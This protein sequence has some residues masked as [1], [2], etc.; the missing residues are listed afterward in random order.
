MIIH[1]YLTDGFFDWG[2]LFLQS[3][4]YHNGED[5]RI[6]MDT[7]DLNA[8]Q[9]KQLKGIYGNLEVKNEPLDFKDISKRAR[10]DEEK[11]KALKAKV[12]RQSV[13]KESK[14]W[15][16]YI[17]VEDR[18]RNTIKRVMEENRKEDYL[19]HMDIDMYVRNKLD[20]LFNF[21]KDYDIS[22]RFRNKKGKET[23]DNRK[24]LGNIIGF[25]ICDD[26]LDFMDTWRK[27]IDAIPLYHKYKGYGQASFWY[28][29]LEHKNN[30]VWGDIP[31]TAK[32]KA[33][34]AI[35][36]TGNKGGKDK[37]LKKCREDFN[38]QS[39]K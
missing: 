35:L 8:K 10:I 6:I 22:I 28:A 11:L 19:L 4:K 26:V 31:E 5:K 32:A 20:F 2:K 29:Y 23:N 3:Y 16:L 15:K 1:T 36:W 25:R 37:Q 18:Y 33:P 27:H 24:V 34:N 13:D 7:R 17:S 14:Y 38:E 12:E 30:L 39:N 9:I 21:I